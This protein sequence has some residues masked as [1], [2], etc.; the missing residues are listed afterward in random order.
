MILSSLKVLKKNKFKTLLIFASSTFAIVSIFL[1]SALSSGL[2]DMYASMLK[3]D[4]DIIITQKGV[5]DTFFSDV[6]RNLGEKI[7]NLDDIKD[8]QALI[9]GAGAIGEI[10]IAGIYGVSEN[11]FSNYKL[12]SGTYP[13]SGEVMLGESV[14]RILRAPNSVMIFNKEF[15][16]SGVFASDIGFEDGGVVVGIEDAEKMFKKSAS[17]LLCTLKERDDFENTLTKINTLSS[18]IEAKKTDDFIKNYNQFKIIKY[19]SAAISSIAFTMGLLSI[20]SIMSIIVNDRKSE[21]GIKRALG[22]GKGS[23]IVSLILESLFISVLSYIFAI[24][25]SY[26]ALAVLK[27]IDRFQG[28]LSGEIEPILA[29]SIFIAAIV[30][31]ILGS[32][33]PAFIASRTDPMVL[34]QKGQS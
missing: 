13:K 8:V 10:N 14:S 18:E 24:V 27:N 3:T 33:F 19:S 6:D 4:G 30:M 32:I 29:L 12:A 9:V 7:K 20:V 34:I 23:I 22:F 31:S 26:A 1:I 17:F 25:L 16:V 15:K 21:F 5:A 11:R 28:Y 2:I